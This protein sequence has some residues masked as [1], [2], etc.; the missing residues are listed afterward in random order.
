LKKTKKKQIIKTMQMTE[1]VIVKNNLEM[2]EKKMFFWIGLGP[3][4]QV[5]YEP[6]LHPE[7]GWWS[8]MVHIAP[9]WG[10]GVHCAL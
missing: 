3:Y 6:I 8:V 7:A 1:K 10:C 5:H 9:Q 2:I 4:R